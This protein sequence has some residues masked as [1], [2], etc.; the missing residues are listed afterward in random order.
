LKLRTFQIQSERY[1]RS[2][3]GRKQSFRAVIQGANRGSPLENPHRALHLKLQ[4][5]NFKC[6]GYINQLLNII[7]SIAMNKKSLIDSWNNSM[8]PTEE[9]LLLLTPEET[10]KCGEIKFKL[11][12]RYQKNIVQQIHSCNSDELK[13]ALK[14]RSEF[15]HNLYDLKNVLIKPFPSRK[16]GKETLKRQIK[17][18]IKKLYQHSIYIKANYA[19]LTTLTIAEDHFLPIIYDILAESYDYLAILEWNAINDNKPVEIISICMRVGECYEKRMEFL[20]A[21]R[22]LQPEAAHTHFDQRIQQT[23]NELNETNQEIEKVKKLIVA[24]ST[25]K[26]RDLSTKQEKRKL[27]QVYEPNLFK[28]IKLKIKELKQ[29]EN[30]IQPHAFNK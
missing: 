12:Q 8:L 17:N 22:D 29:K 21:E 18:L 15:I 27:L 2:H 5:R 30:L 7:K 16:K 20:Q 25:L 14:K 9:K 13:I 19:K 6:N 26:Q 3:A 10:E 28:K 1:T 11:L 4:V 24:N 23:K